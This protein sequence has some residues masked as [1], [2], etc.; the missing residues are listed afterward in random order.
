MQGKYG[1]S[2]AAG[3]T[4][5]KVEPRGERGYYISRPIT[6]RLTIMARTEASTI[7][8]L[9]NASD[10]VLSGEI[11]KMTTNSSSRNTVFF[12]DNHYIRL[13]L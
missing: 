5:E 11:L 8:K 6:H 10:M 4:T 13:Y 3:D 12:C 2:K 7:D 1:I 9:D